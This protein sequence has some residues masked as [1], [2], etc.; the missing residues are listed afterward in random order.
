MSNNNNTN[1]KSNTG[2]RNSGTHKKVKKRSAAAQARR[3][4]KWAA[5]KEGKKMSALA[6]GSEKKAEEEKKK[7]RILSLFPNVMG[8]VGAQG[9]MPNVRKVKTVSKTMKNALNTVP[10]FNNADRAT[11]YPNGTTI[12]G[13]FMEEG[14][15]G[16]AIETLN[17]GVPKR[18]LEQPLVNEE[19]PLQH[20]FKQKQN[21]L[22]KRLLEKGANPNLMVLDHR[23]SEP[24]LIHI[25]N[26][27]VPADRILFFI[28][29]LYTHKA[30]INL[31]DSRG[32]TPLDIAIMWKRDNV[33]EFLLAKGAKLETPN[34]NGFTPVL[35]AIQK[36]NL[37]IFREMLKKG[38]DIDKLTGPSILFPVKVAV[39]SGSQQMLELVLDQNPKTINTKDAEGNTPLHFAVKTNALAKIALLKS[40]GADP[41]IKNKHTVSA[42]NLAEG[43]DSLGDARAY[44]LLKE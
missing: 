41:K 29:E 5:Q 43:L 10:L 35:T 14:N 36:G 19:Y 26:T 2:S 6:K 13:Q 9:F 15:W 25:M 21:A 22:F 44:N 34:P 28:E 7:E 38:I 8:L 11:I 31:R 4:A 16:K 39:I 32:Y 24:L 18:V 42:L 30:D 23:G 3:T 17:K 12:L 20:A 40:A 27:D 37:H 33:A 1:K